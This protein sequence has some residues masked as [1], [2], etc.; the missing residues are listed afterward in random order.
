MKKNEMGSPRLAIHNSQYVLHIAFTLIEL[1]VVIAIIAILAGMLLPALKN[2]KDMAKRSLCMNNQRQI[3]TAL[4]LYISDFA[5]WFPYSTTL[6]TGLS[7]LSL[8]DT[9]GTY[10]QNKLINEDPAWGMYYPPMMN[11]PGDERTGNGHPMRTFAQSGAFTGI[12]STGL[13]FMQIRSPSNFIV[14]AP[15]TNGQEQDLDW[16]WGWYNR[17]KVYN[18]DPNEGKILTLHN[19]TDNFLFS[20]NHVI[21]ENPYNNGISSVLLVRNDDAAWQNTGC[22]KYWDP[23]L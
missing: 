21:C 18:G 9:N 16:D 5:D 12:Q 7:I 20:D 17:L 14:M 15:T 13:K 8:F 22:D 19:K 23:G 11:C 10:L 3:G 2:A 1:L 4:H 6:G